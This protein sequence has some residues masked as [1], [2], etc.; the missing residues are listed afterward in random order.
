[1][2]NIL[3]VEKLSKDF[4]PPLSLVELIKL[5][6]RHRKPVRALEDI[7]FS[8]K[9]S[10]VL[11]VLGPNGAGKTTLLKIIA[12]LILSDKGKVSV[13]GYDSGKDDEMIKSLIGLVTTEER[14][15]YWRLT[16][17]QNL[18]L[19]AALYGLSNKETKSV[20][21]RLLKLFKVDYA[22]RRFDSYSTGMKRKFA[23]IRALLH[24]PEIL[25]LDEPTK[26]LDYNSALELRNFIKNQASEGKTIIL[27]THNIEEAA[28]LC[29]LFMVLNKGRAY[30]FGTLGELSRE[31][32]LS[33]S[34]P[35]I[36]LK[37]TKDA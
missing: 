35:E 20:I 34:L 19:F 9:K 25:L 22:D 32:G 36:Y 31:S 13:K 2:E 21:N 10:A 12:T 15:F 30:G 7:S 27:A 8:I 16:G 29:G 4:I 24:N 6:F 18:E 28:N 5:N 14:S 1:M 37:L 17:R 26:S 11:G 3:E 23:I 33:A